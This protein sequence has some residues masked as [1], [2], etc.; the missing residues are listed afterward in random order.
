MNQGHADIN[1]TL[2][3]KYEDDASRA[4]YARSFT[5]KRK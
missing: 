2:Q 1:T 5:T 4:R 3:Y